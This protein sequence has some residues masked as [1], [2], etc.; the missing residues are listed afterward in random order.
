MRNFQNSLSSVES[1]SS[2]NDNKENEDG[3]A[4]VLTTCA[5]RAEKGWLQVESLKN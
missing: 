1:E 3:N 2:Q 5:G 4:R